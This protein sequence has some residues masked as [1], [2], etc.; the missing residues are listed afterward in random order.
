MLLRRISKHV[1]DENWFAVVLDFVIVVSG[2][3]IGLQLGNWNDARQTQ[4][5]FVEAGERLV[6]E[7]RA[8]LETT[9]KFL[10]DVD[11][12]AAKAKGAISALRACASDEI[13][14]QEILAGVNAIRGTATL[15]L[16][17]TALSAITGN[18]AFLSLLDA[19]ERERLKEFARRLTQSDVTLK[20]LEER[21]FTQH[22]EDG[23]YMNYSELVPFPAMD[24]VMIRNMTLDA[25]IDQIC[26]DKS[27]LKPF[28]LW[29]R[30]ATFQSL[31]AR[32]IRGWLVEN[33][34]A[35]TDGD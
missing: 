32:Q 4:T 11:A 15:H 7:S 13:A 28:Y 19:Q 24:G 17:Q 16:R 27:F 1:K 14:H 9:D 33:I 23:P 35:M 21:P 18:D 3:F 10:N 31:R 8:N 5:A 26:Q 22:I 34:D 30:T 29:E 25:P 20:W 2:V 6:A 12:R